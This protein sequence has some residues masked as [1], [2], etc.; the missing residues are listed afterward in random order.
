VQALQVLLSVQAVIASRSF[1]YRQQTGLFVVPDGDDF[2]AG[3]FRQI[4][5]AEGYAHIDPIATIDFS[6]VR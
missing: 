2:D 1:V 5:D 3:L 6:V 4:A